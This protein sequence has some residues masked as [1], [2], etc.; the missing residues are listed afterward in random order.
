MSS[1]EETIIFEFVE[2]NLEALNELLDSPPVT[3]TYDNVRF[4]TYETLDINVILEGRPLSPTDAESLIN[5]QF[6]RYMKID[7]DLGYPV[8][9]YDGAISDNIVEQCVAVGIMKVIKY[10]LLFVVR[11]IEKVMELNTYLGTRV[12]WYVWQNLDSSP[13]Q[14]QVFPFNIM[15]D[16]I[17]DHCMNGKGLR[18]D[19]PFVLALLEEIQSCLDENAE[20][21][22]IYTF[23]SL[24]SRVV[25]AFKNHST[26]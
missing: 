11:D 19:D 12:C 18:V 20:D 22:T 7:N 21:T 14:M 2:Q 23:M 6:Y 15:R 26:Q 3:R 13:A 17:F 5:Q 4:S 8:P 1:N 24:V 10:P 25:D 16:V 9:I